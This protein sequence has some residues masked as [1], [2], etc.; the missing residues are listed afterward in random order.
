MIDHCVLAFNDSIMQ[1]LYKG[2]VADGLKCI[3]ESIANRFGGFYLQKR[4]VDI[5]DGVEEEEEMSADEIVLSI[6]EKAGLSIKG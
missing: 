2:Y 3:S 1:K 5:T 6:I 4:F